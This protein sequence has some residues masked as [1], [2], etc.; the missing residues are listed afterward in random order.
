MFSTLSFDTPTSD[1]RFGFRVEGENSPF[2]TL[3]VGERKNS[4]AVNIL[5]G[6]VYNDGSRIGTIP[7]CSSPLTMSVIISFNKVLVRWNNSPPQKVLAKPPFYEV[8]IMVCI[9]QNNNLF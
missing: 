3:G 5:N 8:Y 2:Q 6:S 7:N 9:P 1:I 4:I